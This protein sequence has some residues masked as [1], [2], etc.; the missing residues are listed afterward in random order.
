VIYRHDSNDASVEG[1]LLIFRGDFAGDI[2][3]IMSH[4]HGVHDF[5]TL[6]GITLLPMKLLEISLIGI[7]GIKV[8]L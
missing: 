6:L 7:P 1:H 8:D 3:I 5:L 4:L 2:E